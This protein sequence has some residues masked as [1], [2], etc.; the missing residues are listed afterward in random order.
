M[1]IAI[2]TFGTRG[3]VE[4]YVALGLEL[5]AR[6]HDVWLSVPEDFVDWVS[7]FGLTVHAINLDM[8][9]YIRRAER[10]G[11]TRNP[12]KAFKHAK[13]MIDPM[14]DAVL[15]AAVQHTR[16]ADVVIAHPKTLFS[17]MGAERDGACFIMAAPLPIIMPTGAFPMPGTFA[18]N[19][20]AFWNRLTWM[21]LKFAMAPYKKRIN[22]ERET[23]GL[24]KVGS[25]IDYSR[26]MNRPALRLLANSPSIVERPDDWDEKAVITGAW[27]LPPSVA[28]LDPDLEQFLDDGPAP[29]YVGFGS[30][31]TDDANR[32]VQAAVRG[33]KKAHLRGVIARGW[34]ELPETPGDHVHFIDSAP[35]ATL[36]P[37]CCAV[38][39]HGGA[40]T[41]GAALRAGRP[42]LIV[43]F[44]VDQPWWAER[45]Y[46]Q[47]L[48]PQAL[49]PRRL[50]AGRF[51]HALKA[52]VR[53]EA[54]RHR[55]Q[56]V[57]E[58]MARE[59]GTARAADLIEA[60]A[61]DW[62]AH[63]PGRVA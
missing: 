49:K 53:N 34:A 38:V 18:R 47:G 33:L 42:S 63:T 19:H 3:D 52:L 14:L 50:T 62:F 44:M 59:Q 20:G 61:R 54:F 6:G 30:M 26:Y 39:H 31:V 13:D 24:E 45:L 2:Q 16:G 35:H 28:P 1:K 4:P 27:T 48:G 56:A 40:G 17:D 21:P 43:P 51:A 23:L 58:Q 36:F 32:L 22:A 55:C 15:E 25:G 8:G 37:R 7:G 29:V 46:E 41:T 11:I 60:E 5:Q 10:L 9:A 12:L 57:A